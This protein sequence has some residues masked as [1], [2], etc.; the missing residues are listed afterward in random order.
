MCVVDAW[1]CYSNAK[2]VKETQEAYYLK[3][4]EAI[5]DILLYA[6]L[7]KRRSKIG[8]KKQDVTTIPNPLIV[9][10]GRPKDST[11]IHVTPIGRSK[12]GNNSSRTTQLRS[13]KCSHN[14]MSQCGECKPTYAIFSGKTGIELFVK[15]YEEEY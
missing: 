6:D 7:L 14:N 5:I 9:D 1:M 8:D 12:G 2:K 4:S 11:G 10:D 3:L 15:H 13:R